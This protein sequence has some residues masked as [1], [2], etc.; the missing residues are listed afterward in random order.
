MCQDWISL[1]NLRSREVSAAF[2][3]AVLASDFSLSLQSGM[4]ISRSK[5]KTVYFSC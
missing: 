5:W 4:G 3:T 1:S 2:V